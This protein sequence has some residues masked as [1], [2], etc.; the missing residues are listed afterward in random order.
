MRVMLILVGFFGQAVGV[1]SYPYMA[2]LAAQGQL[3]ELNATINKVLRYLS[4]VIPV[5]ILVVVLRHEIVRV[6]FERGQFTADDT[7]MT[8]LILAC[9]MV[10]AIAFVTQTVV[11][12]GFLRHPKH[13][14]ANDFRHN[15][16]GAEPAG[17]LVRIKTDGHRRGRA[18]HIRIRPAADPL[19]IL[20]LEST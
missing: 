1:A 12:R 8:A 17:L 6:L 19:T 3:Q 13:P 9:L 14:A 5:S 10:G 18:G 20:S 15:R 2:R 11:N 16:R 4:I 7:N